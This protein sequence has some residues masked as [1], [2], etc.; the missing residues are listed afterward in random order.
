MATKLVGKL[1]NLICEIK[2]IEKELIL[3]KVGKVKTSVQKIKNWE[4]LG[5]K[6]SD[7]WDN[8]S[9]VE[10]IRQQRGKLW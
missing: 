4:I 10:E 9:A 7:K 1:A 8:V 2:E 5:G 3:E 6:I